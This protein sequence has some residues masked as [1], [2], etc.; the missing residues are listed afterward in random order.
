M[1]LKPVFHQP[2][3]LNLPRLPLAPG[4]ARSQEPQAKLL[5]RHLIQAVEAQG[6][7]GGVPTCWEPL[8]L[9]AVLTGEKDQAEALQE[10]IAQGMGDQLVEFPLPEVIRRLRAGFVLFQHYPSPERLKELMAGI[11][12]IADRWEEMATC[13]DV[14]TAP[15]DLMELLGWLYLASG[16]NGLLTLGTA[17]EKAAM[18]WCSILTTHQQ[19]RDCLADKEIRGYIALLE[20]EEGKPALPATYEM[21]TA[22]ANLLADA[23]R[24]TLWAGIMT[25]SKAQ[26]SA[27]QT[28]FERITRWHGAVGGGWHG[29]TLLGGLSAM[30]GMDAATMGALCE[31]LSAQLMVPDGEWAIQPLETLFHNAMTAALGEESVY[32]LQRDNGLAAD[33]MGQHRFDYPAQSALYALCRLARGYVRRFSTSLMA[34]PQG[35]AWMLLAE[36][37]YSLSH[38]QERMVFNAAMDGEEGDWRSLRLT[39]GEAKGFQLEVYIPDW[40]D[41]C[42]L[43][44]NQ[45]KATVVAPSALHHLKR[46]WKEGDGLYLQLDAR[47]HLESSHRQ[48]IYF[49]RGAQVLVAPFQR[50]DALPVVV[51]DEENNTWAFFDCPEWKKDQGLPLDIPV[52]PKPGDTALSLALVPYGS[53]PNRI[54]L[55]PKGNPA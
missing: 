22:H 16:A 13:V 52:L 43:D 49:R 54:G 28:G 30:Q 1:S 42:R 25:G 31:A 6:G 19:T 10:I 46:A 26:L 34:T 7:V 45:R 37:R 51:A 3:M 32:L 20:Q 18:D 23:M 50:G 53:C 9:L 21:Y 24:F 35:A 8:Y 17:L 38:L 14:L 27:A 15:A 55:F 39:Q 4:Q 44:V 29:D 40:A 12:V 47:I 41:A 5:Y 33:T 11:R 48:G 36:G 2:P